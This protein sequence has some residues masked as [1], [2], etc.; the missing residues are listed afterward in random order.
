MHGTTVLAIKYRKAWWWRKSPGDGGLSI[1]G[2]RIEKVYKV[3]E[4]SAIAIAGAAGPCIELAGLFQT[5]MEHFEKLEG[6]ELST[7]GKANKLSRW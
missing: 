4:H 2:R 5:E 6:M 3:D 1:S 7:D